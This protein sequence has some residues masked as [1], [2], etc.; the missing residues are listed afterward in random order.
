MSLI[1]IKQGDTSPALRATLKRGDGTVPDLSLA[2]AVTLVIRAVGAADDD[3]V[4]REME[5]EDEDAGIVTYQ[6]VGDD[7]DEVGDYNMEIEVAYPDSTE[8]FPSSGYLQL[9]IIPQ[10]DGGTYASPLSDFHEPIRVL[11]NDLDPDIPDYSADQINAAVRFSVNSGKVPGYS[12]TNKGVTPSLTPSNDPPN[13]VRLVYYSAKR[14]SV[15]M[16]DEFFST[17]SMSSRLKAPEGL[18]TDILMEIYKLEH[19]EQ[20]S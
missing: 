12:I 17:R 16:T 13:W 15:A 8:T 4:E 6:W 5:I 10:L 18:I 9:T 2:D 19:G 20:A 3:F 1:T 11:L 14:F 7:T